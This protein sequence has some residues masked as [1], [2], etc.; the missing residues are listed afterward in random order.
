MVLLDATARDCH[1]DSKGI[2]AWVVMGRTHMKRTFR[3]QCPHCTQQVSWPET[4]TY[5][6][7]SERCRLIDLGLW[8]SEDYRLPGE[9]VSPEDMSLH[10]AMADD[11]EPAC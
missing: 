3:R 7:C 6:F 8:A 4:P 11:E 9:P 2:M 10:S 1:T 5:P